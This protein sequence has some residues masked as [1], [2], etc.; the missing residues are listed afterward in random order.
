MPNFPSIP[1]VPLEIANDSLALHTEGRWIKD[2]TGKTIILKGVNKPSLEWDLDSTYWNES[3]WDTI[4]SWGCNV[5][6]IPFTKSWWDNNEPTKDGMNYRDKIE[7]AIT[8]AEQRGMYTIIAMIWWTRTEKLIPMPADIPDWTETWK[9]IATTY[10][11]RPNV[12]FDIWGE[13]H[14]VLSTEW[15]TAAQ[16]CVTDIR[17]TGA[18][19]IILVSVPGWTHDATVIET[20]GPIQANNIAYSYHQYPQE[21]GNSDNVH[22]VKDHLTKLGWKYI[23]DNNIAPIIIGEFGAF[24]NRPLEINFMKALTRIA[25]GQ[26]NN[27]QTDWTMSYL[28]WWFVPYPDQHALIYGDWKTPTNAGKVLID[29]IKASIQ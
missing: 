27:D 9:E 3:D 22:G 14:D 6:R 11:N 12:L 28:A 2:E 20:L 15:W 26:E 7:Q 16:Q 24:P 17:S 8:W 10:K 1:Y 18:Q 21:F 5:V 4:E 23:L 25:N 19:N 13:P 29:A